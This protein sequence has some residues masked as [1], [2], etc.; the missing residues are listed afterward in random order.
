MATLERILL[1]PHYLVHRPNAVTYSRSS[2]RPSIEGLPQIFWKDC[3]PW[4]EA[5][6]WAVER[7]TS[8]EASQELPLPGVYTGDETWSEAISLR[9][10]LSFMGTA[11]ALNRKPAHR[12]LRCFKRSGA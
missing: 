3:T 10:P 4:R 2:S 5:N 1:V 11:S 8:G 7:A 6:L 12:L 9:P